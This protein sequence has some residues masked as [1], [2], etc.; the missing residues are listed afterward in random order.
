MNYN[1]IVQPN[2]WK[3]EMTM[4]HVWKILRCEISHCRTEKLTTMGSTVWAPLCASK[5]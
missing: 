1:S 3:N 4:V 5:L 2:A